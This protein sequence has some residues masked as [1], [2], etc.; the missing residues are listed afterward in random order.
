MIRQGT[1]ERALAYG[2]AGVAGFIDATGFLESG[3]FFVSFMTGNSTRLGVGNAVEQAAVLAAVAL[4]A[5]F[6]TGVVS[7]ALIVRRPGIRADRSILFLVG[8]ALM[9]A[10]AMRLWHP[11]FLPACLA[12]FGM[13]MINLMFRRD[14]EVSIAIGYMTGTLVRF[15]LR[16][17]D[18][19]GGVAPLRHA[20]PFLAMW[21][22]LV[23]GVAAGAIVGGND[24][25]ANYFIAAVALVIAALVVTRVG[26]SE[27]SSS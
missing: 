19:I 11:A 14:G 13:G 12:A 4:I 17:A 26:T 18:A 25:T 2:L 10:G 5:S 22:A 20:L 7:G 9:V 21:L 15:G 6:V 27:A 16:V 8:A 24:W 1:R 23:S 3:G